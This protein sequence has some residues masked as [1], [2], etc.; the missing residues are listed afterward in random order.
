MTETLEKVIERLRQLSAA[1]QDEVASIL[2]TLT[3]STDESI[4][5]GDDERDAVQRGLAEADQG[6]FMSETE[7]RT[8]WNRNRK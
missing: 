1:E 6:A 7:M 4:V 2:R 8:F 3:G 5:L